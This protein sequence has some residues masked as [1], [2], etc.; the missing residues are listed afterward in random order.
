MCVRVC[1]R[2]RVCEREREREKERERKRKTERERE[3][4]RVCACVCVRKRESERERE[5]GVAGPLLPPLAGESEQALPVC[6][7][8]ASRLALSSVCGRVCVCVC[9]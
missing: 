7:P 2:E 3:R 1:V 5:S 8:S 4:K 6:A 9:V